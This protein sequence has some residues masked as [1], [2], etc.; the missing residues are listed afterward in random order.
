MSNV[1]KL[2]FRPNN[3]GALAARI[4]Q[5]IFVL[6]KEYRVIGEYTFK[7]G[8]FTGQSAKYDFYEAIPVEGSGY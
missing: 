3:R 7:R 1:M 4:E 5:D 8:A 2:K 6:P